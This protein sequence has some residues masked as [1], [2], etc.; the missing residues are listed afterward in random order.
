MFIFISDLFL[1]IIVSEYFF[2]L[3]LCE[4]MFLSIKRLFLHFISIFINRKY[5]VNNMLRKFIRDA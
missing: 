4:T 1:L 2:K 3:C 5:I